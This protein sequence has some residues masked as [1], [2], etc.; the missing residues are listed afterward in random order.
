MANEADLSITYI[1]DPYSNRRRILYSWVGDVSWPLHVND[2][3]YDEIK[4]QWPL[5][6]VETDW[7]GMYVICLR[8]DA[9][10]WRITEARIKV[11]WAWQW[12]NARL[13]ATAYVW[14]LLNTP[15]YVAHQWADLKIIKWIK[16]KHES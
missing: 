15:P 7:S 10:Y 16:G 4:N 1:A 14:G 3:T 12:F 6:I 8:T 2:W 9:R 11:H 5:K 13:L